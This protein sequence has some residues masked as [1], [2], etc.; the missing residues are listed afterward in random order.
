MYLLGLGQIGRPKSESHGG[1]GIPL[2]SEAG[3]TKPRGST[4]GSLNPFQDDS[5]Q[6]WQ[7][8]NSSNGSSP[9]VGQES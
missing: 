3:E 6:L 5:T 7:Q 9:E 1:G 2:I 8:R 4:N